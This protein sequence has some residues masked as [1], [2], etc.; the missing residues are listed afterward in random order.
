MKPIAELN[1]FSYQE[2]QTLGYLTFNTPGDDRFFMLELPWKQ[3]RRKESCIPEAIYDV[4]PWNSPR[5]GKCFKVTTPKKTEVDQRSDVLIHRGNFHK[6]T[7][8]CLLPGTGIADI[9]K[10]GL[11]DVNGSGTALERMLEIAP[12]GFQ[13]II[14]SNYIVE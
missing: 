14:T 10:D 13:L 3:N 12:D 9:N 5:F 1:R 11:H 7:L 4:I 6:D 2:K 8:G